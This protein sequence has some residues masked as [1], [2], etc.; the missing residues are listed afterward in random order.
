L[1]L[2]FVVF[3]F[4]YDLRRKITHFIVENEIYWQLFCIFARLLHIFLPLYTKS[5][6]F[7]PSLNRNFRTFA[8]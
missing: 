8:S 6:L 3:I 1:P 7:L 5:T 2:L 4:C